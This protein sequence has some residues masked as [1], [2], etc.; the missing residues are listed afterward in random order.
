MKKLTLDLGNRSYDIL[1]GD[2][3][4]AHLPEYLPL[5]KTAIVVD[6]NVA[7]LHLEKLQAELDKNNISHTSK[8]LPAGEGTKSF[9]YLEEVTEWLL[10]QKIERNS[11]VIAFGGGVIGDLVG[12]AASMAMRGI[13]F[14][15]IPTTLLAQVDSS[16]GGKTAINSRYGKN[17]IGAFY[18]PKLVLADTS[19]LETLP[20]R[21]FLSGYA[22]VVK[23][24]LIDNAEFF[25]WLTENCLDNK[26]NLQQAIYESCKAKAEIVSADEREAGKRALLNFGHTFGHALEAETG[27]SDKLLHGEAVSL[28]MLMAFKFSAELGYCSLQDM[29]K[30]EEYFVKSDLPTDPLK[31]LEEWNAE[32]LVEHMRLDKKV[33][34]G[35]MVFILARGIGEAFIAEDVEEKTLL[36][37]LRNYGH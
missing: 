17:L 27:F 7:N 21:E 8:I 18:Q 30:V 5:K 4:F 13:N 9:K 35:K 26:E 31:Y 2:G 23:Y 25:Q 24:G 32:K 14:I 19:L 33:K 22:E 36:N 34:N 20:E 29:K 6:E 11:T 1:I 28:G 3:L 15:Q 10:E 16:V 12:F 37:F